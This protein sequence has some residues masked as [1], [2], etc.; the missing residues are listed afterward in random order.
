[1]ACV[2]FGDDR[3]QGWIC[4][5][6]DHQ[7]YFC[8]EHTTYLFEFKKMSGPFFFRMEGKNE[9]PVEVDFNDDNEPTSNA[10]LWDMFE[11]W[12]KR[13]ILQEKKDEIL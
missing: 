7:A 4:G 6:P 1:M 11:D 10:F 13:V 8:F 3:V 12:H 2:R 9:I 5:L